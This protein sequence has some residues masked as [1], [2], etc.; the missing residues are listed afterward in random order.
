MPGMVMGE[1]LGLEGLWEGPNLVF[2]RLSAKFGVW[3]PYTPE[4]VMGVESVRMVGGMGRPNSVFQQISTK[5]G[6]VYPYTPGMVMGGWSWG[7]GG[8]WRG[9]EPNSVFQY[10]FTKFGMWYGHGGFEWG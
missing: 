9:K 10:I 1:G 8:G 3:Y 5:F 4:M 7:V 6:M 2:Q